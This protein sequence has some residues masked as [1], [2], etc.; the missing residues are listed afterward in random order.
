MP[1]IDSS[2]IPVAVLVPTGVGQNS[3][4]SALLPPH[5]PLRPAFGIWGTP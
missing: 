2:S 3:H 4:G 5:P 1:T